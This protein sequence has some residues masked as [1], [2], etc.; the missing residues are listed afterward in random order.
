MVEKNFCLDI[1]SFSESCQLFSI[2]YQCRNN[3]ANMVIQRKFLLAKKHFSFLAMLLVI[4]TYCRE[5]KFSGYSF[6]LIAT[7][8]LYIYFLYLCSTHT[9][10]VSGSCS[11]EKKKKERKMP[12]FLVGN[13]SGN[14]S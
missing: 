5:R 8:T 14:G 10:C 12:D 9:N 2:D 6:L 1:F 11:S 7:H 4:S 3:T 13:I